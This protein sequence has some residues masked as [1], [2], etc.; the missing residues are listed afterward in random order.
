MPITFGNSLEQSMLGADLSNVLSSPAPNRQIIVPVPVAAPAETTAK[1]KSAPKQAQPKAQAQP[2][3]QVP[4]ANFG[5][6][7]TF[8]QD[9]VPAV[10]TQPVWHEEL[11]RYLNG[12]PLADAI[13]PPTYQG[14]GMP[15]FSSAQAFAMTPQEYNNVL[16][17]T[18]NNIAFNNK[19]AGDNYNNTL[20]I[21]R[22]LQEADRE[23]QAQYSRNL[24]NRGAIIT[25]NAQQKQ[26][27]FMQSPQEEAEMKL[28]LSG[29]Q[30]RFHAQLQER[31]ETKM[32]GLHHQYRLS[33]IA[34][35][36]AADKEKASKA[37]MQ[38]FQLDAMKTVT[39]TMKDVYLS[40][41]K[42]MQPDDLDRYSKAVGS[43]DSAALNALLNNMQIKDPVSAA[44][45]RAGIQAE[46]YLSRVSGLPMGSILA[47]IQLKDKKSDG[48]PVIKSKEELKKYLSK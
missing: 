25:G 48:V 40:A 15:V 3:P 36:H 4:T 31:L 43:G 35:Q 12:Q 9:A 20:N 5:P 23:E 22:T 28:Q 16:D 1:P 19:V 45:L 21:I 14:F 2:M 13:Q 8:Q 30:S 32:A 29:E 7:P 41:V 24:Q 46:Q 42:G 26:T 18:K 44:N 6:T 10:P 11:G 27:A 39:D 38:Q 47:G 34:A 37:A 17:T 33:E